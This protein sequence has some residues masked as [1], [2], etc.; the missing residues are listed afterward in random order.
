VETEAV[1]APLTE[2]TG[3]YACPSPC[4]AL[5]ADYLAF[6][7]VR[8]SARI[9]LRVPLALTWIGQQNLKRAELN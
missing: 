4:L 5:R 1:P 8:L 9:D 3:Q 2:T 7:V 6:V